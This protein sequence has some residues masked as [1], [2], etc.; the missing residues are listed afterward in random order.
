MTSPESPFEYSDDSTSDT[1]QAAVFTT[2]GLPWRTPAVWIQY[3]ED[4]PRS[5]GGIA[6]FN[7]SPTLAFTFKQLRDTYEAGT[8]DKELDEWIDANIDLGTVYEF[9]QVLMRALVVYGRRFLE[10]Y[11]F[12]IKFLKEDTA[13]FAHTKGTPVYDST[14]QEVAR[15][16]VQIRLLPRR[17]K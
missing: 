5:S 8:A 6:H 9:E 13:E 1:K 12:L 11:R 15:E 4:H 14:G 16:G 17:A 10:N 3:N 2:L 7:F